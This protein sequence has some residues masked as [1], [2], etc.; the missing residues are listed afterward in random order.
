MTGG[1]GTTTATVHRAVYRTHRHASVNFC[2][3]LFMDDH[4]EENRTE[5]N[6]FVAYAA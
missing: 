3:L 6:L 4:D 2:L 5:Q 1:V